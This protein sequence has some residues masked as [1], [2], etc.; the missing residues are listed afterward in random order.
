MSARL[1]EAIREP[2]LGTHPALMPYITAGYPRREGFGE[3]LERVAAV[4]DVLILAPGER[5]LVPTGFAIAVPSGYEAQL[6]PRSGLALRHGVILPNAPG[7]IDSDYRGEIRVILWNAGSEPFEIK[8]GDRIAQLV[9]APVVR[10]HWAEV[11][12]LEVKI[13]QISKEKE[14]FIQAQEFEKAAKCRDKEKEQE[15]IDHAARHPEIFEKKKLLPGTGWEIL[16]PGKMDYIGFGGS[17]VLVALV[18]FLLW[19]VAN[20]GS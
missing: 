19:L 1:E 16:K 8:R 14:A 17:W 7:T 2:R 6:R 12:E 4:A 15:A 5:S 18:I 20:I 13:E 9:V 11:T 10:A 3:M